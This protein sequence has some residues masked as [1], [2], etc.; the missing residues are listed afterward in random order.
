V[1]KLSPGQTRARV[2][3]CRE[4]AEAGGCMYDAAQKIGVELPALSHWLRRSPYQHIRRALKENGSKVRR[5]KLS[6]AEY[7]RRLKLT[8][9]HKQV[10]AAKILG[11]SQQSLSQW[12]QAVAPNGAAAALLDYLPETQ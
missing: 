6:R 12:L 11:I 4:T 3:I 9:Q 8:V 1:A 10:K 5:P 7:I 2:K